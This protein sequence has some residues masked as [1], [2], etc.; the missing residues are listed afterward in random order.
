MLGI[1][2]IGVIMI[3]A[4]IVAGIASILPKKPVGHVCKVCFAVLQADWTHCRA[5]GAPSYLYCVSCHKPLPPGTTT[6]CPYCGHKC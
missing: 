4:L 1:Q 6:Y 3:G 2:L 5:C